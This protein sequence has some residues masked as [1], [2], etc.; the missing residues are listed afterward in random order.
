MTSDF[1]MAERYQFSS[2]RLQLSGLRTTRIAALCRLPNL[3][4]FGA[5]LEPDV[6]TMR[7]R[8]H[9][10][11]PHPCPATEGQNR[12]IY[13]PDLIAQRKSPVF[14]TLEDEF[15]SLRARHFGTKLGTPKLAVFA[16]E[17]ATSV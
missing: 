11:R 3:G 6:R 14:N 2:Q 13:T 10:G 7:A 1:R 5:F 12:P 17:A 4:L 16:L 8:T 15:E 9:G